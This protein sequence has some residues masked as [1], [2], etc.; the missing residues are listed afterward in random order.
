MK[1]TQ[2]RLNACSKWHM[3][4]CASGKQTLSNDRSLTQRNI[5]ALNGRIHKQTNKQTN[6]FQTFHVAN[7]QLCTASDSC[8]PWFENPLLK[9][10]EEIFVNPLSAYV[11]AIKVNPLSW[12]RRNR[13]IAFRE[14]GVI[15]HIMKVTK[16]LVDSAKFR[17]NQ[18]KHKQLQPYSH[19][20]NIKLS[21]L[22]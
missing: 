21:A 4:R 1:V 14:F 22:C 12:I 15:S 16:N 10:A 20:H 9:N 3:T 7:C 11:L 5:R 2:E 8:I 18:H 13:I 17:S 6:H 19:R